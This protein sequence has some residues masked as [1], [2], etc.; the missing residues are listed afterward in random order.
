MLTFT[1]LVSAQNIAYV[2]QERILET[3][4]KFKENSIRIDSLKKAYLEDIKLAKEKVSVDFQRL[5][6]NYKVTNK[7]TLEEI[8]KRMNKSDLSKLEIIEEEDK[9]IDKRTKNYE[10]VLNADREATIQPI[11]DTI[12]KTVSSYATKNKIDMVYILEQISP[13]LAYVD[14]NKDITAKIIE[15]LNLQNK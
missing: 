12:N 6:A 9:L 5:L 1:S 11:I 8:K 13:A 3:L 4:P 15:L 2:S 14:K 7:E 10:V